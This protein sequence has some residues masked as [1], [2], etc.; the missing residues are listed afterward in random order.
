ML[1]VHETQ[2]G[3]CVLSNIKTAIAERGYHANMKVR[4]TLIEIVLLLAA[5]AVSLGW[6]VVANQK[7]SIN[8]GIDWNETLLATPEGYSLGLSA[9]PPYRNKEKLR[10]VAFL[11]GWAQCRHD[12]L[13]DDQVGGNAYPYQ[14]DN[15]PWT[16]ICRENTNVPLDVYTP[17]WQKGVQ[18]C[19]DQIAELLKSTDPKTLR[20][21]LIL[22]WYRRYIPMA[23]YTAIFVFALVFLLKKR[24][25]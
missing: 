13:F 17:A 16:E 14:A 6:V 10:K 24:G 5:V 18:K 8:Q 20:Q 4:F 23:S 2:F 7:T 19:S 15:L 1:G 25:E 11:S 9:A 3:C 12:F 22:P 21:K